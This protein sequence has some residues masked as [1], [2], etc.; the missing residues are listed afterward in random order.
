MH[1]W[2]WRRDWVL[3]GLLAS[4]LACAR[5]GDIQPGTGAAG[6]RLGEDRSAVERTLGKPE[7]V[8]STG[9]V[10]AD[11]KRR[12]QM[13]LLYPGKGLDVLLDEGKVRSIFLYHDG[14][15]DHRKYPG[16]GP[17]G[18]TVDSKRDQ[19]LAALGEPSARG[20]GND[21]DLWFR[22]DSGIEFTF[23]TDGTL[24]HLIITHSR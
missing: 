19:V 20:I 2:K 23:Q 7:Q 11:K 17:S 13:Y 24:H 6:V 3:L 9:V 5:G 12:E 16:T 4:G 8:N 10:G 15:D 1:G 21:A 18:L 14:A 22:Y